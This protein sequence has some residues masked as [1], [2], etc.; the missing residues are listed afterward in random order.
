MIW[1]RS[2]ILQVAFVV[3]LAFC[4]PQPVAA[5]AREMIVYPPDRALLSGGETP[6]LLGYRADTTPGSL[7]ITGKDGSR[8]QPVGSGSFSVKVAL[9]PGENVLELGNSK[10]TVFVA[11]A[12]AP[13]SGYG[14]ADTHAVDNDCTECHSFAGGAAKLLDKP[15]KLCARCHDD[16]LKGKDGKTWPVAH[17]P[18]QEGDCLACH[19][20]HGLSIKREPAAARRER[21]FGCHDDFTAGGKKKMHA[22][23]AKGECAS[24]HGVHGSTG[25]KLLPATGLKLCL[26]CHANP[27]QSKDAK[28]W[29]VPHPALD[30]GCASCHLPHVADT[31]RLLVKPEADL[32]ADCH[33]PFPAEKGGKKQVLHSPVEEGQCGECHAV[34]GSD[35]K[36]L[37]AAS[38]KALCVK[39]HDDTT[40]GPDGKPWA[41]D[42]PAL[43]DGCQ[44]CHLPHVSPV[45][46]LL[47]KPQ[48]PLC[49]ECHEVFQVPDAGKG[50]SLH[51]PVAKGEC[52][53]CHGV[54]GSAQ[55]KLLLAAADKAL[56][57]KCH[58]DPALDPDGAPWTVPHPALDD[59]CPA[60]HKPHLSNVPRLL[61]KLQ[62][63]LCAGC[64]DDKSVNGEGNA[65]VSP[66]APVAAGLCS[67]CHGSHGSRE[68]ALLRKNQYEI[69]FTC[70]PEVHEKH[71]R[72][73]LDPVTLQ[74]E[75]G[76]ATLPPGFPARKSD[77][78]LSCV[79]C[80]QPHGSDA[81]YMWTKDENSF[82]FFCHTKF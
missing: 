1:R 76:K 6:S 10:V 65:W 66:H 5:A 71:Q 39:C 51:V 81:Q 62:K 75:S 11:G 43:D 55:K 7:S 48:A 70:H 8:T 50:G 3:A 34:H 29:T 57:L 21:C 63:P 12:E 2:T 31:R 78:R 42:H 56:C 37:L 44:G 52:S 4:V 49:F 64:H 17:P 13:P 47:R 54:H 14:P 41:F 38:G 35:A 72:T 20:F 67:S 59:G 40:L 25:K 73:D 61:T 28:P 74:P 27:A 36:R 82:C 30:D 68:K 69:C 60:C 16:M 18:A 80:H 46:G 33:E 77:G 45:A 22:P 53:L 24:C 79:G 9:D 26:L 15:Q 32:C 58:K 19:V 23:V